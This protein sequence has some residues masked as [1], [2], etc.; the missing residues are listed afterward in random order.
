MQGQAEDRSLL[1]TS[2]AAIRC[3]GARYIELC[4]RIRVPPDQQLTTA[5]HLLTLTEGSRPPRPFTAHQNKPLHTYQPPPPHS[6]PPPK[7]QKRRLDEAISTDAYHAAA[8]L[9]NGD[10]PSARPIERPPKFSSQPPAASRN[11]IYEQAPHTLKQQPMHVQAGS[12]GPAIVHPQ[13]LDLALPP[14]DLAVRVTCNKIEGLLYPATCKVMYKKQEYTATQFEQLCGAGSAKKWKV[15]LKVVPGSVPECGIG[16][17]SRGLA[18]VKEC[19]VHIHLNLI[20]RSFIAETTL[21]SS[22]KCLLVLDT[23]TFMRSK[24]PK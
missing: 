19:Q 13:M 5:I 1:A 6:S 10:V 12:Y 15:S 24:S 9:V 18:S 7:S 14:S 4:E 11:P 8:Q 16:T 3:T 17:T 20:L 23:K 21:T 22:W 2:K